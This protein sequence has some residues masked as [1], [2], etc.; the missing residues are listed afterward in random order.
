M[1]KGDACFKRSSQPTR[2][3]RHVQQLLSAVLETSKEAVET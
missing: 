3:D 1:E 2:G